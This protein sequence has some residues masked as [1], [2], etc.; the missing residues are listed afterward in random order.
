[1]KLFT[2]L[3]LIFLTLLCIFLIVALFL[4]T[5]IRVQRLIS[6]RATPERIFEELNTVKNWEKWSPWHKL[7]PQMK[8]TYEGPASGVGAKYVWESQQ[9]SVG[10]GS[11]TI[12]ESVPNE[13]V[14]TAMDFRDQGQ[15]TGAFL[16]NKDDQNTTVVWSMETDLGKNPVARY[17]G[18]F[19]KKMIGPQFEQGLQKLKDLC[20][21]K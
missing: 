4:P 19:I 12:T 21:R 10:S 16:L 1:M 15:A 18:F 8:L 20:E 6:I 14:Y 3:L 11:L 17:F 5:K 13:K 7:D 2:K 9:K